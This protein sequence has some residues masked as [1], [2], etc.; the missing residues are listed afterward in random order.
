M[1][2]PLCLCPLGRPAVSSSV[3]AEPLAR[4]ATTN[5]LPKEGPMPTNEEVRAALRDVMDPEIGKPIE[6]VGMLKDIRVEGDTVTVAVLL[7]IEGCPLRERIETD[8]TAA[9]A[10][11]P[12]VGHVQVVLGTMSED[13]RG[14]L[15][16]KLRGGRPEQPQFFTD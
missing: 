13:Q 14:A 9:V 1:T 8:V 15:V 2:R 10:P 5:P 11:L 7:T 6:D 16:S 3:R 12:G 4:T